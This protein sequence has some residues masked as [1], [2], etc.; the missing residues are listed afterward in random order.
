MLGTATGKKLDLSKLTDEEAKH[1]WEVIQRDFDLRKKEEDRLGELKTKIEREDIKR[2]LLGNR[3]SL[4][5]SHCIRCLQPFKFLVN[6]KLQ[7]LDCQLYVCRSCSHFSKNEQGWVC[8]PCHMTRVL[9]IGTLEW[10]HKTVQARFRRFGS[11]KVMHSLFK[12]LSGKHSSSQ[13]DF[14]ELPDYETQSM[15]DVYSMYDEPSADAADLQHFGLMKK[16]KRR[17]TV[18]PLDFMPGRDHFNSSRRLEDQALHEVVHVDVPD[19]AV[20]FR[21]IVQNQRKSPD[22]EIPPQHDDF[23]ENRSVPSRSVSR[24]SYSSCGSGGATSAR[25]CSSFLPELDGSE[26]EDNFCQQFPMYQSHEEGSSHTSE[27][28]LS[29]AP[30]IMDLNQRLSAI[31]TLL[32]RLELKVTSVRNKENQQPT[33][34][35]AS[36]PLQLEDVDSEE[37]QLRQKLHQMTNNISDH[38]LT[39]DDEESFRPLSPPE[40]P[41][42]RS[43]QGDGKPS[44]TPTRPSSR[45]ST[46]NSKPE[47][48]QTAAQKICYPTDSDEKKEL[49]LQEM[50][51]SS[52]KGSTALLVELEDKVA[53][54]AASVQ[55]AETEVSSIENRIAALNATGVPVEKRK[56]S[57][58]PVPARRLSHNFPT[59]SGNDAGLMRRRLSV[60]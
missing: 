17:L 20:I 32:N 21:Q 50:L 4:T 40:M 11:A 55:S 51:V 7:C 23:M 36:P 1:V 12:R 39:S 22:M 30:Q 48:E 33:P 53:Q 58:V 13:S 60:M 29:A 42:W 31:E 46:V 3:T 2:Q 15:P 14:G 43:P 8:D 25:M 19:M 54:A 6:I 26:P 24:L 16:T 45:T 44:R 47:E 27:E 34:P 49:P 37:Q 38:S 28:S 59:K 18:D 10:Y 52:F 35:R 9:K 56:R 57:A 5:E 41:A